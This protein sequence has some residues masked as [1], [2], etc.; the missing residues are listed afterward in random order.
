MALKSFLNKMG[1]VEDE[2]VVT[3]PAAPAAKPTQSYTPSAPQPTYVPTPQV[4]PAISEMLAQSLQ[5]NKLS[6]FDY[7]KFSSSVEETKTFGVPEDA[8]YKMA[9][10]TA[11]Q[12]GVDKNNLLKSGQHYL[13]VLSQ[14]E[15][16]FNADC[17]QYDKKEIQSRKSKITEISNTIGDLTTKLAQLQQEQ[18]TLAQELQDE[19]ARLES[20]KNAFQVT[21]QTFR[22]TI[23]SNIEKINQYLQ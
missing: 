3:K 20:R 6:G 14:D 2:I 23:Q 11:K 17:D 4:D 7:L 21:L 5:E 15:N 19:T 22:A 1:L 13:D 12:L 8:R 16:D 9:F 10:S 18:T